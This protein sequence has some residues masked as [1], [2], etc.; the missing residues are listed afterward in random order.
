MLAAIPELVERFI[1]D[2]Q[3]AFAELIRRHREKVYSVAFRML[4]NHLDADEV[5]QE[6]FVRIYRRRKEL[7]N[8]THFSTF[9]MRIATN[10]AI[11][12]LRR[13]RGHSSIAADASSLSGATQMDLAQRVP[14]P[15]QMYENKVVMEE[16]QAALKKLPP[17]QRITAILHDIEGYTKEEIAAVFDCPQATVRSNLHIAR[18]KLR[19]LLGQRLRAK[20]QK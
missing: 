8:V 15:Q 11:D 9:L 13:R 17:K 19:K 3:A 5:V 4:G 18:S 12:M 14:T 16:I 7:S 1:K 2:D 6:T 20:E 10:Y